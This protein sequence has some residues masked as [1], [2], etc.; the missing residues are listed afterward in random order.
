MIVIYIIKNKINDKVYVGQTCKPIDTR[1]SQHKYYSE[2]NQGKCIKLERAINKYGSENFYIELL[3]SSE[4]QDVANE[5]EKYYIKQYDCIDNGYNIKEGG[6]NGALPQ[7]VKDKISVAQLGAKNHMYGKHLSDETKQ[8][9]SD[10]VSGENH[11]LYGKQHSEETKRL[12]GESSKGRENFWKG[13][14]LPLEI[15]RKMS[16]TRKKNKIAVGERNPSAKLT[17][18]Q[19]EE[20]RL[21]IPQMKYKDIALKYNISISTVQRI[22]SGNR[23][24]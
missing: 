12:I 4:D 5:L 16:D 8:K 11:P 23:W 18:A 7:S 15:V 2:T 20:I 13:K 1:F 22:K 9:I 3:D 19:V 14:E 21:L 24:K 6:A 10:K 17:L